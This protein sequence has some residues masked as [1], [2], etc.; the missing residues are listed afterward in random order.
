MDINTGLIHIYHGDGKGKTTCATGLA[1]RCAGGGGK[2][3]YYQ[4]LKNG[5]SGEINI[6]KNISNITVMEGYEK[7]KFSFLMTEEEER[8]TK[9]YYGNKLK[10]ISEKISIEDYQLLV[11]DEVLHAVNKG[12]IE[13]EELLDFIKNKPEKL[14]VVLTG[15]DPKEELL[16]IADYV[17]E[18]KKI[19]HPFDRGVASRHLIE[20]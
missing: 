6:L 19:K 9:E 3:L 10:E 13:L 4:F 16:E 17:T 12:Y 1:V 2:V 5:S 15:R 20:D 18:M 11:L 14:E 8:E 7:I